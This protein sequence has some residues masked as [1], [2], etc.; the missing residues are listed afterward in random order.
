R[1]ELEALARDERAVEARRQALTAKTGAETAAQTEALAWARR[2]DEAQQA[3]ARARQRLEQARE[4]AA[5]GERARALTDLQAQMATL[6]QTLQQARD[7]AT[8]LA[9]VQA[10]AQALAVPAAALQRLR[11]QAESLRDAE[12]Q[13]QAAA[14]VLTFDLAEGQSLRLGEEEITGQQRRTLVQPG[15]VHIPG[16]G[17]VAVQPGGADTATWAARREALQA[18]LRAQCQALGVVDLAE[19]EERARQ[20]AQREAEA[21]A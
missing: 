13:L 10:E 5:R 16:K 20:A 6:A 21:R 3:E 11:R 2:H 17:T 1:G 8:R 12:V 4:A 15:V 19:A 14:T 7:A 9:T 18:E